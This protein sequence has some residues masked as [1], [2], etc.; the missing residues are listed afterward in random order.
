MRDITANSSIVLT[1]RAPI[2][3]ASVSFV[4]FYFLIYSNS[5]S[6]LRLH[7]DGTA[8]YNLPYV[9]IFLKE[10]EPDFLYFGIFIVYTH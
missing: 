6:S 10:D 1:A 5:A 8:P 7:A 9:Q 4:L 2:L 3:T